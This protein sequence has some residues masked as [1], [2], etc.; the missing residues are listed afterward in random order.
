MDAPVR[1][2]R[3]N[4]CT[5]AEIARTVAAGEARCEDVV[6][7]CLERVAEREPAVGAWQHLD[8]DHAIAQA[9]ALDKA[10]A[11][12]PLHGVP[13][14]IKD[15]IDTRD[16][17][18]EYGSPIYAGHRPAADAACVALSRKAG[19]ILMGK[20]VTTEFANRHP[21][22]TRHPRDPRRTP[23]GSSSG[24]AAA[25]GDHM[26]PLAIGTQTTASTIRPAA[27]CGCV[28]YRPTWSDLRMHGV[29]EAAGSLDTL[30]LIARSVE[31]IALYRDVLL[32]IAPQPIPA[33]PAP[34]RVGFCRTHLWRL[35]DPVY[36]SKLEEAA[37]RL[38]RAGA[39]VVEVT[40][41]P[42]F[43]RVE[44][45]HRWIS[46]FE[47]SR[48]FTHE[49]EHHWEK[50]SAALRNG[51]LKDGLGCSF[52]RY[53]EARSFAETLRLKLDAIF[54]DYDV[55]M[56]ACSDGEAPLGLDSTGNA[57][58]CAIWTTMHVPAITLPV[59]TGANGLPLG[60]QL[61]ARRNDDRRLF[62]AADWAWRA[63]S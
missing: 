16:L 25:V 52:E 42:E 55:L 45:A 59:F 43:E 8:P 11:R 32:G 22:K 62:A 33:P 61:V 39:S 14:G 38:G 44:D 63:L 9:R 29:R 4:E 28:G 26:V 34:L 46:S 40:L 54:A 6:R 19:G 13:F 17:P 20:T 37:Q 15:I 2:R 1:A 3:L 5:A 27:F 36:Q 49:I 51:R 10:G 31:D 12:G 47:F 58:F 41:P 7:A 21:G 23:G 60:L 30:G 56:A 57:A 53:V 24:S 50:I 48:N 35:V 18:T